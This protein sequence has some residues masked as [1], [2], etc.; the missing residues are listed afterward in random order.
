[1]RQTHHWAALV[2]VA[3]MVA[4]LVRVF[5]TGAFRNRAS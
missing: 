5:F 4:H 1:M 2:F 3:A